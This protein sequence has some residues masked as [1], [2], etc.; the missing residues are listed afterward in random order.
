MLLDPGKIA[1]VFDTLATLGSKE[2]TWLFACGPALL[3]V[4]VQQP[5]RTSPHRFV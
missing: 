1:R 3:S 4:R 2:R 5:A